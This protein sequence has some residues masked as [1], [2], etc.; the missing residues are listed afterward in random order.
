[1][2]DF[3]QHC[4]CC[5]VFLCGSCHRWAHANPVRAREDGWIVSRYVAE[6]GTVTVKTK[7]GER[8]HL[9]DGSIE[10]L[11]GVDGAEG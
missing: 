6:P 1:M 8:R 2:V 5:L 7:W 11:S 9:C 3:H 4:A 10:W